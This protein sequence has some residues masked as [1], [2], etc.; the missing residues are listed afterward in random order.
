MLWQDQQT[1]PPSPTPLHLPRIHILGKVCTSYSSF[2][3]PW[4]QV[5]YLHDAPAYDSPPLVRQHALF[6]LSYGMYLLYSR[7]R[8]LKIKIRILRPQP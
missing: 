4:R 3:M 7:C 2:D 1:V 8:Y 5:Y 6:P